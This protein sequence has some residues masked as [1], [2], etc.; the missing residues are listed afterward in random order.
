MSVLTMVLAAGTVAGMTFQLAAGRLAARFA[1]RRPPPTGHRPPVTLL[2]PLCGAEPGL[3][4]DLA[5]FWRD[6]WPG[7][8]M[9]CGVGDADDPAVEAVRTL[10]ARLPAADI[11]L[12]VGGPARAGNAKV[13]N[14][15][16][17]LPHAGA[18][19]LVMAD[20][21]MRAG[22]GYLEAV[23]GALAA[24]DAGLATCLYVG[25]PE[26]GL[27]SRLGAMGINHGFLPSVLVGRALGRSDGC[28]G[29]TMALARDT[30][31]QAGGLAACA[32][33]LADDYQLGRAVRGTGRSIALAPTLV[34]TRVD[35]S[36][37]GDLAAHELR[38][39]RTI[40]SVAPLAALA[41][42]VTQPALAW[43]A[44]PTVAWP[45][46]PA[47]LACRWWAVRAQER[48]LG[49]PTAP[50]WL[51]VLRDWLS[52]ALFTAALCGRS[53]T[54]RGRRYRIRRDG[55]LESLA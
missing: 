6:D 18:G 38:W 10:Q 21:D 43:A 53:V 29:A 14:L 32:E 2:K 33:V 50:L 3:A 37:W 52:L 25:R 28:F 24:P 41:S 34:D 8:R 49:L 26:Q 45:L 4:D 15:M 47:A 48:A 1:S 36:G 16:N 31:D 51:I 9:V 5:T 13:A 12:V 55:T 46:L 17:M 54:W 11:R 27:P 39:S 40:A 30:L 35:E 19:I 22:P 7:L 23:V 42:V 20:S 44:L